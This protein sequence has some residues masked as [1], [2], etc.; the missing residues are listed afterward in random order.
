MKRNKNKKR[1]RRRDRVKEEIYVLD[2]SILIRKGKC[3]G[4]LI[5][6]IGTTSIAIAA[7]VLLLQCR[8]PSTSP[9]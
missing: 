8:Q 3:A 5:R 9:C 6:G 4:F 2:A 1:K 7:V